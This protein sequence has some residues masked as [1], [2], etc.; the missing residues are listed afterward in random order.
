L[1]DK[2]S[3]DDQEAIVRARIEC[4]DSLRVIAGRYGVSDYSIRMVLLR[5][6]ITLGKPRLSEHQRSEIRR[7]SR[8][9][10]SNMEISRRTGVPES[11]VAL[12]LAAPTK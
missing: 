9:G 10:I 4:G 7:L 6:G 12:V 11:S 2:L 1:R 5:A 8:V 3:L